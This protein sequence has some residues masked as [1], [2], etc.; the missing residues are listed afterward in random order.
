MVPLLLL[1]LLAAAPTEG[2]NIRGDRRGGHTHHHHHPR[3]SDQPRFKAVGEADDLLST[4]APDDSNAA[5]S[6]VAL[7]AKVADFFSSGKYMKHLDSTSL[8]CTDSGIVSDSEGSQSVEKPTIPEIYLAMQQIPQITR[9]IHA[10][11][12][13]AFGVT[14]SDSSKFCGQKYAIEVFE[15]VYRNL[16]NAMSEAITSVDPSK[17]LEQMSSSIVTAM[18]VA[19]K[20]INAGAGSTTKYAGDIVIVIDAGS[21]KS[22]IEMVRTCCKH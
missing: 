1:L 15:K 2:S 18:N 17:L 21:S 10:F 5:T 13:K 4:C 11:H 7:F 22:N 20:E 19:T 6:S 14:G 12:L 8:T 9:L 3:L 16:F